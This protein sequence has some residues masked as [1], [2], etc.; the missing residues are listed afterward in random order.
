MNMHA[1]RGA[2]WAVTGAAVLALTVGLVSPAAATATA[3]PPATAAVA[4]SVPSAPLTNLAHL[5][6][7][8]DQATPPADVEGHTTYRL[9]EEPTLT[10]PWTYADARDGGTFE[11]VGGGPLD[12]AT[13]YWGQGAYNADDISRAAVVYL[14]HFEQTGDEASADKA[15]ELLRGLTYMQTVTGPNAGNVVLWMQPDGTLNPSAEPIEL[16]DPSDSGASYWLART[17]WALGEG[18]AAFADVDPA[19][20]AFLDERLDLAL[21]ALDRQVLSRY[22]EWTE[23]DG[24]RVPAWLIVDGADAS[25][26]AVIGLAARVAAGPDAPAARDALAKLADGIAAMSAGDEKSWPYGAVLPWAQS[27]SMWHAWASQMPAALAV[28]SDVLDDPSLLEPAVADTAVFTPTL[29]T[30]GGADNGWFPSPTDRV[31]IAYGVDSRVQSLLSV[32]DATGS[33]GLEGLA[34]LQ[35]A[36]YF[37]AN[38][39]GEPMYDAATGVT[40][41]GLQP[42]GSINRNSGAES[43]IHGLLTMLAL[44]AHPAVAARATALTTVAAQDG[45][46]VVEA[47]TAVTT[48]GTVTTPESWTGESSWSGDAL[49]L[50][51]GEEA[52]WDVGPADTRRW[53]EPVVWS[54]PGETSRSTWRSGGQLT[55]RGPAQGIS[56]TPGVLLPYALTAPLSANRDEVSVKALSGELMLD[57]ILV[58]PWLPRLVLEGDGARTELVQSTATGTQRA[59]LGADGVESTIR[60]FDEAG[61]LVRT[62]SVTGETSVVVPRGGFALAEG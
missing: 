41:D 19:F 53:L 20:A 7:L 26:E 48:D 35:A 31:Q 34:G 24:L 1:R 44:D 61:E 12:P 21:Q 4:T 13:G 6:F 58:R 49:S 39:A 11:R 17:I 8:L 3:T 37:G 60:V 16:P 30:A 56:P 32:A 23:S 42:D 45:L 59:T 51:P 43:A 47:E 40:Y 25:A 57:A 29:L 62:T 27:R 54:D 28:A 38:R 46:R 52:T 5:D 9:A 22:G 55:V 50:A 14:R 15:Y 2:R 18:Y 33:A 10:F 36:W